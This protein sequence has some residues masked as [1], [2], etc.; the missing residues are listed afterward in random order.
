MSEIDR[1]YNESRS[2]KLGVGW[3]A[4]AASL[5]VVAGIFKILDAIWAFKYDGE[6]SENLQTVLFDSDLAAWGWI[7]L[8]LG[9]LLIV[10]G[11][12][13]V[14]GM[15]WA[16]W[17][18]VVVLAVAAITNYSWIVFRPFWTLVMEGIYGA[19]IYGLLVYGGR[20]DDFRP[21]ASS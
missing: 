3:L 5:L 2:T 1:M 12:A 19:A 4:F 20:R 16:R 18:G 11:F 17:F 10:A 21:P 6:I 7:W 9:I 14:K 8:L 13:V 15:E